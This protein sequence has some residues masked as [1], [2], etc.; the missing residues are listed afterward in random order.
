MNTTTPR[1]R[2]VQSNAMPAE[3]SMARTARAA[4]R[5]GL[6][7]SATTGIRF[8]IEPGA[9]RTAVPVRSAIVGAVLAVAVVVGAL[10][11]GAS[12]NTLVSH[13]ALYGWNWRYELLSAYAGDEDLPQ[14]QTATLLD[15][16]HYIDAWS[17]IYFAT[18]AIDHQTVPVLGADPGAR[19][20]PPLLSGHAFRA[21][22]QIVLGATTLTML[23]KHLG[24]T[25]TVDNGSTTPR[26]LHIVGTATMPTIGQPGSVHP[27]MGAGA[28]LDYQ[29]I[30][31]AIRNLQQSA[32]PGPQ[33]VLV[34][35]RHGA[36]PA[37]AY[38]SLQ[39]INTA[40]PTA[41]GVISVQ[42]P[43]EIVN[44]R[45]MGTTPTILGA[46]LAAGAVAALALTLIASV[47]RRRRDLAL[48]KTLGF[49]HRQ[50]GAVV[51]WQSSI[52]VAIGVAMGVPIGI[53]FGRWLWNLFAHTI[54]AV[55][56]PTIPT[57]SI[58]LVALA[59]LALANIV[60]ALPARQAAR[61]QTAELLRAE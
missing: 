15:H 35:F 51:A 58:A 16:D 37:A 60:A 20:E 23:H 56:Q 44:Y 28:L 38:R 19:V 13:P 2:I 1:P 48:L 41:G 40:L 45:S 24:D 22:D 18:L 61:T 59:A 57:L 52:A 3:G 10:T 7:V 36:N 6:P 26:R 25:V 11:F 12:L 47:R 53:I 46:A 43:A 27:T 42:R 32:V 9:G 14:Q 29:L 50:L 54:H 8:A 39:A 17:G 5:S 49:T 31:A 4:A 30:P 34:R 55:P 33:A 21:S